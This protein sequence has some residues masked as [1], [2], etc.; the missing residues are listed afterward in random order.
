MR[1]TRRQRWSMT[2]GCSENSGFCVMKSLGGFSEITVLAFSNFFLSD[3]AD[4]GSQVIYPE[5]ECDR[6]GIFPWL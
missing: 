6:T 1:T 4:T 5:W 2:T 3:P